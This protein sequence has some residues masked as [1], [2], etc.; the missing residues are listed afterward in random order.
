MMRDTDQANRDRDEFILKLC[1][2]AGAVATQWLLW[3]MVV[4]LK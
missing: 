2:L 4:G 1:L 3:G